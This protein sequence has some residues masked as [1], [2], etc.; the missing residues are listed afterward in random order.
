MKQTLSYSWA[1]TT[2][3]SCIRAALAALIITSKLLASGEGG[4]GLMDG[5]YPIS[6]SQAAKVLDKAVFVDLNGAET[7]EQIGYIEGSIWVSPDNWEKLLDFLPADK[8]KPLIMYC[9]NALCITSSTAALK[10]T[11]AGYGEVYVMSGG[12]ERWV[13]LGN[14]VLR[15]KPGERALVQGFGSKSWLEAKDIEG[16]K[17]N[18]HRDFTFSTAPSCRDCHGS[19]GK[20]INLESANNRAKVNANCTS[21]HKQESADF[22]LSIHTT[23]K[24]QEH[25][26]LC[27]DCHSVHA[28]MPHGFALQMKNFSDSK[29]GA[30][31]EKQMNTY[32]ETFHGKAM[33]LQNPGKLSTVAA[34]FDCH[35][36]HKVLPSNVPGS[37]LHGQN[38][39]DT[40]KACHPEANANFANFL[41]HADH[42][43]GKNYPYLFWAYVFMTALIVTV[44]GFFGLHTFLWWLR[45][46][47]WRLREPA[48]FKASRH[49]AHSDKNLLR[50]FSL[51]H[52]IQHF[53]MATSFMGLT[54]SGIPQ[55]FYTTAWAGV[56]I[57]FMGGPIAATKIHHYCAFIMFAVFFSH[58]AEIIYVGIKKRDLV[59]IN[60]KYSFKKAMDALFGP[61]SLMPNK[62][63]FKDLAAHFR[64]FLHRGPRPQFDRWTYWE[65][66]D[67]LAVF[68]GM[69]IIGISGLV[70]LYPT[71]FAKV[72]PGWGLNLAALV[73]SDEALL[74]TGFIFA[75]HFFNTH[76]RTD[77][78]PMDTVIFSGV[79]SQEEMK[80]ERM[81][82]YERLEASGELRTTFERH[83]KFDSY[84]IYA[85]SAG[86]L[87]LFTGMAILFLIVYVHIKILFEAFA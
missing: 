28:S 41:A 38:R 19:L 21:C 26:P 13:L 42:T 36:P 63:D 24:W 31:H 78:F 59:K 1:K 35:S 85:K 33:S 46:L 77:R 25:A 57:D 82:W 70:L 16:F 75:V 66:F 73:H 40:C 10:A 62:Q 79:L 18:V 14:A 23:T 84:K 4:M 37:S 50:R 11:Q 34:C 83:S 61:N 60:G 69:F 3:K 54:L 86:F 49:K 76:F 22:A 56:M 68:W 81:R 43:D 67:Y 80:Q 7:R 12:I 8:S 15:A 9:T 39:I 58:L 71:L 51:L 47:C 6:V 30:C 74:A 64:W 20:Q 72:L 53:F 29:C 5:T 87:L 52:I 17:D 27:S 44:F 45:L 2:L 48:H 65:K 55:K 32:H